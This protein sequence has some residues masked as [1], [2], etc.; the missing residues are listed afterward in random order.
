MRPAAG[1]PIRLRP[2]PTRRPSS[3][4]AAAR[5]GPPQ[6][7]IPGVRGFHGDREPRQPPRVAQ[8]PR[9]AEDHISDRGNTAEPVEE[10]LYP[11]GRRCF[12][13]GGSRGRGA[14][15]AHQVP[16][17]PLEVLLHLGRGR[18]FRG[19]APRNQPEASSACPFGQGPLPA[20]GG[21]VPG[22]GGGLD[23]NGGD[24][25]HPHARRR[26][27]GPVQKA[28]KGQPGVVAVITS[29]PVIVALAARACQSAPQA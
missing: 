6:D 4:C 8:S 9:H 23:D 10:P 29:H 3:A 7:A 5:P 14:T 19:K 27:P 13:P 12:R 18:R 21:P 17:H 28:H 11:A 25:V 2:W 16:Q 1:L 15:L 26:G 24:K 20:P 22:P